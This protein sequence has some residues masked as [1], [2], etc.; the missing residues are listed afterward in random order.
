MITRIVKMHFQADKTAEFLTFFETIK[1]KVA[2]QPNC[3]GMKLLRDINNP[4][5]LFTYS[6]WDDETAL[7][8]YRDSELFGQVWPTIKPW[9]QEKAEA[10]S[11]EEEFD[12]MTKQ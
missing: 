1:W 12:G 6:K 2:Q 10:W 7:N 8:T 11:I 4:N 9:F 5:I 3:H